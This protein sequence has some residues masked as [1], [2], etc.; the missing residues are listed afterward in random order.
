MKLNYKTFFSTSFQKNI[1]TL[2]SGTVIAQI[3]NVIGALF[4]AKIYAP[5]LYGT[6]SVFLSFVSILTIINSL[7]LEYIVITDKSDKKSENMVNAILVIIALISFF[8]LIFFIF[9]RAFFLEHA[10]TYTI[11]L[12]SSVSSLF[13][14]NSKLLESYA[15]RKSKFKNIANARVLLSICTVLFQFFLFYISENGLIYGYSGAV[16]I[17]FLFYYLTSKKIIGKP[18][19]KLFK[20]T[21]K[22]HK[23]ILRFAFPSGVINSIANYILPILIL[24]YFSVA[25]SGVYALS[26]KVVSVPLFIISSSISQVYF[27]KASEYFNHAKHKLH[28]FTKKVAFTNILIMLGILLII[29]TLG[30]Y[31]LDIFFNKD[32]DNL[33]MYILILSFFVLG[34]A[35]FSPISSLIVIINKMHVGLF[36]NIALALV[37]FIAIYIGSIYN[38]IIYTVLIFS[39]IGGVGYFALLIYFLGLLK[40]YKDETNIN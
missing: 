20:E 16:F 37:N 11:L 35:A 10:I 17:T 3:V 32:W 34:Q 40:T 1:A 19:M 13:L 27:Q 12:Y 9:F 26:L 7:K 31:L 30:I 33:T 25:Q 36:F 5:E 18:N 15:T 39:I 38:N 6:Y 24:A 22:N 28:N 4:L 8:Y 2:F 21:I 23:N 14:S 29:N